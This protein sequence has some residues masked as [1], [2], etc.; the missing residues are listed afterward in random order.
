MKTIR[1]LQPKKITFGSGCASDCVA[2]LLERRARRVFVLT[3]SSV[4]A[5]WER[6]AEALRAEKA[7]VTT[8]SPD[9]GEPTLPSSP[10]F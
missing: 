3:S 4:A 9:S 7:A 6:W 1:L 10:S 2:D 5:K 8:F